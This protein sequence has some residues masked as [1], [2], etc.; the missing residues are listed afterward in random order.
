[1]VASTNGNIDVVA[2]LLSMGATIN[3]AENLHKHNALCIAISNGHIDVVQFLLEKGIY[4]Y[5]YIYINI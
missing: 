5:I 1:M 3:N 4:I 2:A